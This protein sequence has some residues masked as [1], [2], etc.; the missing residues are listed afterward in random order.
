MKNNVKKIT[1][2][3]LCATSLITAAVFLSFLDE[4]KALTTGEIIAHTDVAGGVLEYLQT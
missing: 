3:F 2:P 1:I 4:K